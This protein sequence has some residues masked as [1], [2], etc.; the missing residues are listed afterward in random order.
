MHKERFGFLESFFNIIRDSRVF[1]G[2][3]V[4]LEAHANLR[5][6]IEAKSGSGRIYART[7]YASAD[8]RIQ[9]TGVI[10]SE[11]TGS[12]LCNFQM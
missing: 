10:K 5:Y 8:L 1:H 3:S 9:P 2:A 4:Y 6:G 11:S 7:S 12:R